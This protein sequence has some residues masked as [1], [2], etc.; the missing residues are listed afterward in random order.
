MADNSTAFVQWV[1]QYERVKNGE[2]KLQNSL[3]SLV[4]HHLRTAKTEKLLP[5]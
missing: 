3:T 1:T 4:I 2:K 5:R